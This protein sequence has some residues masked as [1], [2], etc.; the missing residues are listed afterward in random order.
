MEACPHSFRSATEEPVCRSHPGSGCFWSLLLLIT[1]P[2]ARAHADPPS[3]AAPPALPVTVTTALSSYRAEKAGAGA[4][5]PPPMDATSKPAPTLEVSGF[6]DLYY[7]YN[8]N[9]PPAY[10]D[11]PGGER[12]R[13]DIENKLRNFDFKHNEF[14][15]NLA[16]VVIQ[17]AAAPVGFRI[18]LD[19]GKATEWVHLSEPGG[20][21]YENIQ[22]AYL[23][24]PVR[25]WR[26]TGTLDLGKFVTHHGAEVIETGDNWNYSRGFLF[27]WA[28]PYYHAGLRL[29]LP[30]TD[31]SGATLFLYNGWNNVEDNNNAPSFGLQYNR[32]LGRRLTFAQNWTGGPELNDDNSHWRHL[33]DTLLTYQV[34]AKTTSMLNFDYARESRPGGD[35]SWIGLAGYLR[36]ALN[37]RQ[38]IAARAEWFDD[39]D[40]ATTGT[41][42]SLKEITLTYEW[43]HRG[44]L[45]TRAEARYDWSD[46][47]VFDKDDG[48]SKR[49]PT[50]LVG[51]IYSF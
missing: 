50:F 47:N 39:R 8:F 6:I 29:R 3:T 9:R 12:V 13:N 32:S 2:G 35:V 27:A 4:D 17:R 21:T 38:A 25:L 42:Q 34:S 10:I 20:D 19:Y 51:V 37:E 31:T 24:A 33:F 44:G 11:R 46:E 5:T 22:Q 41:V 14:A 16:E 36:H 28:I 40:G 26:R 15:L 49:Q 23:T 43:K 48:S 1:V 45:L 30:F 18:D 7:E